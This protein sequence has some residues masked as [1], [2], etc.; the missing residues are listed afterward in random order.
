MMCALEETLVL[1]DF[2]MCALEETLVLWDFMMCAL[3]ETRVLLKTR[4]KMRSHY[5]SPIFLAS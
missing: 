3:E 2:M 1:R 5:P 4:F